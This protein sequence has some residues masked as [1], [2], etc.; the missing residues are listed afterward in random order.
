MMVYNSHGETI[1]QR[2]PEIEKEAAHDFLSSA[3]FFRSPVIIVR[4]DLQAIV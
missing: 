4:A 2:K 3:S 1:R